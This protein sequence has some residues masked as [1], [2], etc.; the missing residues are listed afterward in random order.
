MAD[1]TVRA[2]LSAKDENF[3]STFE[4]AADLTQSFSKRVSSGLGFGVWQAVGMKAVNAVTGAL[5]GMVGGVVE[6]GKTFDSSM[7]QVAATMGKSVSEIQDLRDFAQEMGAKTAFSASQAAD[8]LN[9]MAL[10]GYDSTKSMQM[11]PNVLNLAAAGGFDLARASDMVTDT[12]TAFGISMERTT[13]MVDEMAKA[14][15]TGNT[16]VE[17]LGD[18]FLTVGGLA[19]ELNGGFVTLADGTRKP[20]D[21]VQELEIAL[22]AMANAGV[23]G[24]EAGTHMRNMLLK[25][26]DPASEGTKALESMGVSVFDL[27]GNMRSLSDIFGDLDKS[28]SGMTQEKKIQTIADL[29]NTRDLASAEAILGAVGDD[30]NKIGAAILDAGGAAQQMA[31]TQLDNLEG[32]MT[33]FKSALE[34][35]QISISDNFSGPMR[36]AVE[37][38]TAGLTALTDMV[39]KA[40]DVFNGAFDLEA[41]QN[42]LKDN[43]ISGA[44]GTMVGSL[45]KLP[46]G[47]KMAAAAAGAMGAAIAGSKVFDA[48]GSAWKAV[49]EGGVLLQ[50]LADKGKKAFKELGY[51]ALN[52]SSK[53]FPQ[54][55]RGLSDAGTK[56]EDAFKAFKD[57]SLI[58]DLKKNPVFQSLSAGFGKVAGVAK[59]ASSAT[60]KVFGKMGSGLNKMM[61]MALKALMPAAMIGVVLAGFGL[62]YSAF[63]DQ[64]DGILQMARTKGPEI[65]TNLS[66]GIASRVPELVSKGADLLKGL[67][68]TM[69][70]N[71]PAIISGGANIITALVR[72][73]TASLPTLIPTAA[74]TVMT[75][76][77]SIVSQIPNLIV[78]GL[79]LLQGLA[80]GIVNS[81]PVLISKGKEAVTGFINGM[82]ENFPTILSTAASIITTLL[83]GITSNLPALIGG[84][85][86]CI[87]SLASGFLQNLP[88]IITTGIQVIGALAEGIATAFVTLVGNIPT[89]F[90]QLVDAIMGVDWLAVGSQILQA[91]GDGIAGGFGWIGEKLGAVFGGGGGQIEAQEGGQQSGQTYV[92]SATQAITAG[93]GDVSAATNLLGLSGAQGLATG[94][95]DGL[96]GL[97]LTSILT[98]PFDTAGGSL[99]ASVTSMVSDITST[100]DTGASDW[101]SAA[102]KGMD[103][104]NT[105]LTQGGTKAVAIAKT[106]G[107]QVT[108]TLEAAAPRA[109]QAGVFIGTGLANGMQSQLSRVRSI[110][111]Q[112]AEAANKAIEAKARI[113]SPSK[114]T[115]QYG[116]WYGEGFVNGIE[117]MVKQAYAASEDLVNIPNA[118]GFSSFGGDWNIS[119][120]PEMYDRPIVVYTTMDV[121]GRQFATATADSRDR[122]DARRARNRSRKVGFA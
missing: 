52:F 39:K 13:Q 70:A 73:V 10:A 76:V 20:V 9:Y 118:S 89:L 64:I 3:T 56:V 60:L 51:D 69:T 90:G 7:S 111:A 106:S 46:E 104:L 49:K 14:A 36:A 63:G 40:G 107:T 45:D 27:N 81:L 77:T 16:S 72:G 19:Q 48:G 99:D 41:I 113:G 47:F 100:F 85:V 93:T 91:I 34:G 95:S 18:A 4:K 92:A 75:L 53:H 80:Q 23:K 78:T 84:A 115:T 2:I 37:I 11:L 12:Q 38:G 6:A 61:G 110:A 43:G 94:V 117:S 109:R 44:I 105:A 25:L 8:A 101:K 97:D 82:S 15:S 116:A 114:I 59:K 28:M 54:M 120:D 30:W 108:T 98:T 62:L 55:L 35:L 22:T 67:L 66:N 57:N 86:S 5:G 29:F 42:A 103:G 83:G 31:N 119:A 32:D 1:R 71:I 96:S 58:G 50:G 24:S 102:Q 122:V 33:L 88:V 87:A 79:Q 26:S 21:G 65:I 121:D 74:H 17:Q 112:L 68:T